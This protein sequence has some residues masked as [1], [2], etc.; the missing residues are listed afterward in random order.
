MSVTLADVEA[1]IAAVLANGEEWRMGDTQRKTNLERLYMLRNRLR[2]EASS[3]S[4]SGF[5]VVA[6]GKAKAEST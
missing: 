6:F 4:S 5:S 2:A 3:A 1:E